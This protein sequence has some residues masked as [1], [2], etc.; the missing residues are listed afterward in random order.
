MNRKDDRTLD[1]TSNDEFAVASAM[2]WFVRVRRTPVSDRDLGDFGKWLMQCDSH[3][4][5]GM[6]CHGACCFKTSPF[7]GS[8]AVNDYGNGG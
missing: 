2:K 6:S 5:P 8:R 1:A 7:V 3:R 4:G